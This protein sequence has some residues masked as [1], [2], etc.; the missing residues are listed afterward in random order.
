MLQ[1]TCLVPGKSK[2]IKMSSVAP[3][4][5]LVTPRMVLMILLF[6]MI[7]GINKGELKNDKKHESGRSG[8]VY[9][10]DGTKIYKGEYKK[11][12]S[13]TEY[14]TDDI[15]MYEGEYKDDKYHQLH[16]FLPFLG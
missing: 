14:W 12:G 1:S 6:A 5:L 10:T 7:I 9:L 11:H 16:Y 2:K 13:G 8:T 4:Y 3:M 15:K